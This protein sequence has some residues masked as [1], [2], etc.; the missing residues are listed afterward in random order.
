MLHLR[1]FDNAQLSK[2][3]KQSLLII[4]KVKIRIVIDKSIV[5]IYNPLVIAVTSGAL[6]YQFQV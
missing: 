1:G 2:K 3:V 4:S 6:F 5:I